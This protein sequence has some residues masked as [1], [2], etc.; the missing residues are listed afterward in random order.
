ML[1][2]K[3]Q[4]HKFNSSGMLNNNMVIREMA[5]KYKEAMESALGGYNT[6]A[7]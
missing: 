2:S 5:Y 3:G 7:F 1:D 4:I 6:N